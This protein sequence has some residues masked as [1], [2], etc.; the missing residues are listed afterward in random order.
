MGNEEGGRLHNLSYQRFFFSLVAKGKEKEAKYL[1][2][3]D[4]KMAT[5]K[6][7]AASRA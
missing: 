2:S 1:L 3:R 6:R 5:L 4:I 7:S